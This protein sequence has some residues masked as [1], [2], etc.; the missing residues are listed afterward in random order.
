MAGVVIQLLLLNGPEGAIRM[1][2]FLSD[3]T[4]P[5]GTVW[6]G[7]AG[8]LNISARDVSNSEDGGSLVVQ[9]N[10]YD[11]SLI[12]EASK[13]GVLRS[14]FRVSNVII[15]ADTLQQQGEEF[16][17][18]EGLCETPDIDANPE[19]G[20]ITLTV[21]SPLLDLGRPRRRVLRGAELLADY[22]P[23]LT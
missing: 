5:F 2:T 21:Q 11:A 23:G 10:G 19:S 1:T 9:W 4:D 14:K 15:D 18:W 3:W 8:V 16:D 22:D 20:S 12:A 13:P 7:G 17:V 6:K